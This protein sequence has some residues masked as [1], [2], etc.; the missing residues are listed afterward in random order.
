[1]T[2]TE[3]VDRSIASLRAHHDR[4]TE[5]VGA[6]TDEQL[7]LP[8]AA[9]EWRICDVLSHLG[10]GA[11]VMLRPV[12]AAI[13]GEPVGD[14]D[15]PAVWARWD[16]ASPQEQAGWYVQHDARFV[17][18]LE[19]LGAEQRAALAVDLGF[20]PQPVPLVTAVG[21]RLNEVALHSWDVLA[22]LDDAAPLDAEAAEVLLELMTGPMSFLPGFVAK[23]DVLREH[24]VVA[25]EGHGLI[26]AET[27]ELIAEPPAAPTAR[28]VG[29]PEAFV[30][31]LTGRLGED[32]TP[33][34]VAVSGNLSL[35]DLRAVFPGY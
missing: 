8:S 18:T 20:L 2:D 27:V 12:A 32:V 10:S 34:G 19:A 13:A 30:R 5:L 35:A 28:F 25:A 31:L 24:A 26:L 29:E 16:A 22:G 1:M 7:V 23:L 11:E 33:D 9:A 17:E 14:G 3:L 6:M 15:N 4:L 21:M